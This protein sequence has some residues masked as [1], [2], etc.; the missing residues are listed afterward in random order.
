M[1]NVIKKRPKVRP[2]KDG[3]L[4]WR[5]YQE[6]GRSRKEALL[7]TLKANNVSQAVFMKDTLLERKIDNIPFRRIRIYKEFFYEIDFEKD[8]TPIQILPAKTYESARDA[9]SEN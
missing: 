8:L 7:T 2:L 4:L 5:A 9:Q 3:N 6:S 1:P